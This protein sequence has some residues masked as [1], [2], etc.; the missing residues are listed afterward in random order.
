M[1]RNKIHLLIV[2]CLSVL[3]LG[4]VIQAAAP[5]YPL[6]TDVTLTWWMELHP[7]VALV[8]KNFGDTDF[9]KE[10]QKRTGVKV[11]FLHPAVG[12]AD[13][14]FNL[15]L[16]SG[17]FPDIVEYSWFGVP[18]GVASAYDNK[19]IIKLNPILD[20]HAP[21][22]KNYLKTNPQYAKMVMDDQSNY[23]VFPFI[24]GDE[25][26]IGTKG[27][28]IRK[29][30]LDELG[31]KVPETIDEWYQA[32][33]AFKEKKGATLP[34]SLEAVNLS[35]CFAGGFDNFDSFYVDHGKVKNGI[36]EPNR[37]LFLETMRKWYNEGLL[38]RNYATV[39][40]KNL[41]A[42]F[43]TGKS[44]ATYGQGGS[45]LGRYLDAMKDKDAK[46]NM[47]AAP[48][49]SPKK[50]QL[51]RFAKRSLPAGEPGNQGNAAIT[52]RCKNVELAAR[53][54]DYGY[55]KE[56]NMFYNFGIEGT[57]YKM[58]KGYPTYTE[59]I[60][61]NPQ[62]LSN[63]QVMS[64]YMRGHTNGPF[65][66]DKRYLEQYYETPQQKQAM[67]IWKNNDYSKYRLPPVTPQA[68]EG[69]ELAKIM[70]EI[71]T[72]SDEMTLK[73]IMGVEPLDHFPQFVAQLNKLGLPR[74]IAIYQAAL[75]RYHKRK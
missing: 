2:V 46:F 64:K 33:K 30:W 35:V 67:Q 24:R 5:V 56:G 75:D 37:K 11:K 4:S 10:L 1:N 60:M 45:V 32:L 48:F 58:V 49:P 54:L 27:P 17:D 47:V 71:N 73:F 70:N 61:R 62:N 3:L 34:L 22:L 74:A 63:T 69:Q 16:A 57:S 12:Q 36:T 42:Y 43:M 59:L 21:N 52:T 23:Y 7:N 50:G 51:P 20:K 6:K 41:D 25:S 14:A 29:D 9:A 44:G 40:R 13:E 18:G 39:T 8:A 26:L 53:L 68:E 72:Y 19:Y 31:L 55:S 28:L 66:Q 65:V 15:L 38:D